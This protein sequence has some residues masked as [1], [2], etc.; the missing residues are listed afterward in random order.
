MNENGS[1]KYL[2]QS[3]FNHLCMSYQI[4]N[5]DDLNATKSFELTIAS[6]GQIW[7]VIDTIGTL[8]H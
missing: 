8:W 7:T 2:K 3:V 5:S 6:K 4:I 1:F